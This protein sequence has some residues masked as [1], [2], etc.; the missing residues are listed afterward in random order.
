MSIRNLL[1]GLVLAAVA[2]SPQADP[3]PSD[4]TG[5]TSAKLTPF[6]CSVGAV[7]Q[8]KCWTCH[9][10]ETAFGAPMPLLYAEDV[11]AKTRDG[12]QEI[13][14]RIA[15]RI[16]DPASPMPMKGYPKLTSEEMSILDTWAAQGGP[17]GT[18]CGGPQPATGTGG[19]TGAPGG[20][21][22]PP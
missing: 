1:G 18:G 6:P 16:H 22:A 15:Q 17:A 8:S 4:K 19:T 5:I 10:A 13:Y 12:T 20:G 14:Q 9:G 21:G 7:L 11:H 2:C 3:A